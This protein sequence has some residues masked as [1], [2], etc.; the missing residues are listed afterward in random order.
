MDASRDA[1]CRPRFENAL[2]FESVLIHEQALLA[3]HFA[4]AHQVARHYFMNIARGLLRLIGSE[5]QLPVGKLR[6]RRGGEHKIKPPQYYT[7][8][9]VGLGSMNWEGEMTR[10]WEACI[11]SYSDRSEDKPGSIRLEASTGE[12][13]EFV[14]DRSEF[15]A[16]LTALEGEGWEIKGTKLMAVSKDTFFLCRY[17]NDQPRE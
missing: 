15:D 14:G 16:M 11:A 3:F 6:A 9:L 8:A 1:D 5:G 7:F 17:I 13:V 4:N 2:L 10:G 12:H